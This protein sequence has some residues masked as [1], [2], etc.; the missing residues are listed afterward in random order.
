[1]ATRRMRLFSLACF[2]L[3]ISFSNMAKA[4]TISGN[5]GSADI[6]IN[7]ADIFVGNIFNS[8]GRTISDLHIE[9]I[10]SGGQTFQNDH[11][12]PLTP[13]SSYVLDSFGGHLQYSF[14]SSP[15]RLLVD[16]I[17]SATWTY[18]VP[19]PATWLLSFSGILALLLVGRTS[20]RLKWLAWLQQLHH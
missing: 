6:S 20:N 1:M 14:Q 12:L 7:G 9:Y 8:S 16:S 19:E 3:F 11:D 4:I 10:V 2:A 15:S 18:P 5:L 13:T 17:V